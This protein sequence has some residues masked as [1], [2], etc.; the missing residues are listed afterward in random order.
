MVKKIYDKCFILRNI[1]L[2]YATVVSIWLTIMS[3]LDRFELFIYVAQSNS[4]TQAAAVVGITKASLSKQIK[5]LEED[6]KVDLFTRHGQRL[7]LTDKVSS[8]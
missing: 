7:Q 5:R 3:D 1:E 2:K 8:C 4:L 6:L